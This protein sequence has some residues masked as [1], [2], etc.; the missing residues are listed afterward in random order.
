MVITDG[1][2]FYE[3]VARRVFGPACLYAQIIKTRRNDRIIKVERRPVIG[4]AWRFE[5]ALLASEDSSTLNSPVH[6]TAEKP[7]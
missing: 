5:S 3:R 6:G 4:A 2:E 1:F 7:T